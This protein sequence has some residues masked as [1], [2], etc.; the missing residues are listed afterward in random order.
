[1]GKIM[2]AWA[3]QFYNSAAWREC[4]A[5]FLASKGWL[6]ERH[7]AKGELEPATIA[8]HMTYLTQDNIHDP[9]ISLS[10]EN[11]EALCQQCHNDEHHGSGQERKYYFDSEGNL[12]ETHPPPSSEFQFGGFNTEGGPTNS[13]ARAREGGVVLGAG[14]RNLGDLR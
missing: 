8:H 13:R 10:W 6:C 4:R 9:E 12:C 11:L 3:E 1:M 2:K 5:A 7:A 14:A